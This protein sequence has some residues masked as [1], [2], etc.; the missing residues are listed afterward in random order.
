MNLYSFSENKGIERE[1]KR[2]MAQSY[3]FKP[4]GSLQRRPGVGCSWS[5]RHRRTSREP[6]RG[7]SWGD[8]SG[9]WRQRGRKA[10]SDD[11]DQMQN[12]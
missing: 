1:I 9:C 12:P 4:I 7:R 11:T 10:G 5:E 3:R 8:W 6:I 2:G